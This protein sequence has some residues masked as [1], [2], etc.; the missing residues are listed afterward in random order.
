[1]SLNKITKTAL[2]ALGEVCQ[3]IVQNDDCTGDDVKDFLE[4]LVFIMRD[5]QVEKGAGEA[6]IGFT[7]AGW[8][9]NRWLNKQK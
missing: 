4:C 3:R 7:L 2:E 8:Y 1:M 9:I 6:G 5:R